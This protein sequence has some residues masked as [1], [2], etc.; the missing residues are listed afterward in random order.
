[1]AKSSDVELPNWRLDAKQT[2]CRFEVECVSQQGDLDNTEQSNELDKVHGEPKNVHGEVGFVC[3][4]P[5]SCHGK[6][7]SSCR[8]LGGGEELD[9]LCKELNSELGRE[10]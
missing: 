4:E 9:K 6:L 5:I 8:E 1:M 3:G 2:R 10:H 7:K